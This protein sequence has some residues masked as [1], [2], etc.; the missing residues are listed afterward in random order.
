M[1]TYG[2]NPRESRRHYRGD[3]SA[4]LG[5]VAGAIISVG[6]KPSLTET[7]IAATPTRASA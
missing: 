5:A 6:V 1:L 2:G 4:Q 3:E 7:L